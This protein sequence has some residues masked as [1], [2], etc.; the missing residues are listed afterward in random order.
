MHETLKAFLALGT[1]L[2]MMPALWLTFEKARQPGWAWLVPGYNLYA[3]CRMAGRPGWWTVLLLVPGLNLVALCML[4][5]AIAKAFGFGP[6]M[7][8]LM[9]FLPFVA[10]P[11]LGFGRARYRTPLRP[12]RP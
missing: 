6:G 5:H 11:V 10:F 7:T 4:F 12:H 2:L 8:L 9:L 1:L 3:L